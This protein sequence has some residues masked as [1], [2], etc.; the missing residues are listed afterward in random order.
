MTDLYPHQQCAIRELG[1]GKR[2]IQLDYGYGK[3]RIAIEYAKHLAH[4]NGTKQQLPILILTK[5]HNINT[6]LA[7]LDRWNPTAMLWI[8]EGT[9]ASRQRI[10][11]VA[12]QDKAS[13][14]ILLTNYDILRR[15][16][17]LLKAPRPAELFSV[18]IA[19]ES[20]AI[21]N[22]KSKTTK[23]CHELIPLS[24][25]RIALTGN[26]TPEGP[27]E[28]WAQLTFCHGHEMLGSYYRFLNR[29]FVKAE[30]GWSLSVD[31]YDE[32][33]SIIDLTVIR[34]QEGEQLKLPPLIHVMEY[35]E[36]SHEQRD[37]IKSI[38]KEWQIDENTPLDYWIT[39]LGKI[40]QICS[41]FYYDN[42]K[43]THYL[44]TNPKAE[45]LKRI[46]SQLIDE[47]EKAS[48]VI[49]YAYNAEIQT[50]LTA[51]LDAGISAS[52]LINMEPVESK[53]PTIYILPIRKSAGINT[54]IQC[55]VAIFYDNMWSHE[56]RVQ[57]EK[58]VHRIGSNIHKRV[59]LVDLC[60]LGAHDE[61]IITA[62]RTKKLSSK[63]L[64]D[65]LISMT[66]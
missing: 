17:S 36:L 33:Q 14:N 62:L 13:N 60:C 66:R 19:D 10:W 8:V 54:L 21:K 64:Y 16:I 7:E 37:L 58:R 34:I 11:E 41:G 29:H 43:N 1:S 15:D 51:L 47:D 26:P 57:A 42:D 20:T 12:V 56:T 3:S 46:V 30:Y 9:L 24:R 5:K 38:S 50:I 52:H 6:W 28:L 27:H 2:L 4:G 45:L 22:H 23:A 63:Y 25:V 44:T 31:S 40:H 32:M 59:R 18:V 49:W 53:Q 65:T 39:A 55:S 48:F 35:Y 61:E